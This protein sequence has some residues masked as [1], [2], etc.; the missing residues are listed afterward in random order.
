M[1]YKVCEK[2]KSKKKKEKT[3]DINL[4][5]WWTQIMLRFA[6][7]FEVIFSKTALYL[8]KH[9]KSRPEPEAM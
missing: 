1:S 8:M 6:R 2:K 7:S 9:I 5:M 4:H 3:L